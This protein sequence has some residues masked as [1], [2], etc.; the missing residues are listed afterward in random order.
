MS[1]PVDKAP[2]K[3]RSDLTAA[4]ALYLPEGYPAL[5]GEMATL[6]RAK[7][8]S[9]AYLEQD[10]AAEVALEITEHIRDQFGG[11]TQYIPKGW[12]FE[13]S[14]RAREIYKDFNGK[15]YEAFVRKYKLTEVRIRQIIKFVIAAERAARQGSLF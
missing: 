3:A 7:L 13:N 15:N 1:E 10:K 11:H 12:L 5:L 14:E 4:D 6:I 9:L 2:A 8:V